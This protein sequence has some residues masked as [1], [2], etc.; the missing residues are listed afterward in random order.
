MQHPALSLVISYTLKSVSPDVNTAIVFLK[1]V[2]LV[3]YTCHFFIFDLH[4]LFYLSGFSVG[5][6]CLGCF[7]WY[8]LFTF[9]VTNYQISSLPFLVILWVSTSGG[10]GLLGALVE[11]V[12]VVQTGFLPL[13]SPAPVSVLWLYLSCLP[14]TGNIHFIESTLVSLWCFCVNTDFST[15]CNIPKELTCCWHQ[16]LNLWVKQRNLVSNYITS[17]CKISPVG[18]R[19][20][21]KD[22]SNVCSEYQTILLFKKRGI[23]CVPC[24]CSLIFLPSWCSQFPPVIPS[25]CRKRGHSFGVDVL[26]TNPIMF[27]CSECPGFP[28]TSERQSV[29][30]RI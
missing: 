27:L 4:P 13:P 8:R 24:L 18:I 23:I 10:G 12:S 25:T 30:Y 1:K 3:W 22:V 29:G 21:P 2:M 6:I 14:V 28:L 15:Y 19:N 17:F 9:H 26:A 16:D 7:S 20:R 11:A 5:S